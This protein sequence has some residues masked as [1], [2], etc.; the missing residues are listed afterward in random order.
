MTDFRVKVLSGVL[1][2]IERRFVGLL[3]WW[4]I[5]MIDQRR[6]KLSFVTLSIN[7]AGILRLTSYRYAP[8]LLI[9]KQ[10]LGNTLTKDL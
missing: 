6:S 4:R 5:P 3:F 9:D 10:A 1:A 8:V 7:S 2:F